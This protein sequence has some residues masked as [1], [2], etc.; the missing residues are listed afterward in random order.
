MGSDSSSSKGE[1]SDNKDQSSHSDKS[2]NNSGNT[3]SNSKE[4]SLSNEAYNSNSCSEILRASTSI[5]IDFVPGVGN[6]KAICESIRGKDLITGYKLSPSERILTAGFALIP[7]G[8]G[9]KNVGKVSLK[10]A[11]NSGNAT[12]IV[13]N[14]T[15][16][17][18]E[19]KAIKNVEKEIN[20]LNKTKTFTKEENIK[21]YTE[22]MGYPRSEIGGS[23]KPKFHIVKCKNRKD[24]IEKAKNAS[25]HNKP[26]IKHSAH[27][28]KE[29]GKKKIGN[30]YHPSDN[31]GSPKKVHYV[32]EDE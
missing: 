22:K 7:G 8:S 11:K 27:Y 18:K 3:N 29:T 23:G 17:E 15:K 30:H 19:V 14:A 32:Y 28:D 4:E 26:P 21:F 10:I 20:S 13:K 6:V 16:I 5:A 24:L 2:Y 9:V 12:K 1:S 25:S 31:K